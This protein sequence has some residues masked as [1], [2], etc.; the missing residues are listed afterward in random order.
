MYNFGIIMQ[1][2]ELTDHETIRLPIKLTKHLQN[3]LTSFSRVSS[4]T[5][6]VK[7]NINKCVFHKCLVIGRYVL[8][9]YNGRFAREYKQEPSDIPEEWM[10]ITEEEALNS[11]NWFFSER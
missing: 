2:Y 6:F 9:R 4:V 11:L 5:V 3:S 10:T 1:M 8:M 7:K